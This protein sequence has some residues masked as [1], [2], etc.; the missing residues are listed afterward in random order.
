MPGITL[1]LLALHDSGRRKYGEADG[2]GDIRWVSI[3]IGD[4]Q[5]LPFAAAFV[6]RLGK[7]I[8]GSVIISHT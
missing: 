4:E 1:K 7:A 2:A 8:R 5:G 6:Y 3:G